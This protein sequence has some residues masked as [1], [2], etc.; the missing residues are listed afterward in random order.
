MEDAIWRIPQFSQL[1]GVDRNDSASRMILVEQYEPAV[2][3][4]AYYQAGW[5][6]VTRVPLNANYEPDH[7]CVAVGKIM[8]FSEWELNQNPKCWQQWIR[9][10]VV[11]IIHNMQI[12]H[13]WETRKELKLV[14][15]EEENERRK[16]GECV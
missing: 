2:S 3:Y 7:K 4:I 10:D 15:Q 9:D 12:E 6:T 16:N 1:H 13:P 5:V 14:L 11:Y 8:T